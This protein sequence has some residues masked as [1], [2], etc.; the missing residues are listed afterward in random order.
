M[1]LSTLV[2]TITALILTSSL[3]NSPIQANGYWTRV[4]LR[5][6]GSDETL[7]AGTVLTAGG[8]VTPKSNQAYICDGTNNGAHTTPGGTVISAID[9]APLK[10]GWDGTWYK[11]FR[12]YLISS[13]ENEDG[14]SER[15][16]GLLVNYRLSN[17]GGCQTKVAADD[18]VLVARGALDAQAFLEARVNTA[19]FT[20]TTSGTHT[21]TFTVT[22]G[23]DRK[24]VAGATMIPGPSTSTTDQNGVVKLPVSNT[25]GTFTYKATGSGMIRSPPVI[26]TVVTARSSVFCMTPTP[27]PTSMVDGDGFRCCN[28]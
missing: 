27:T 18:Q 4:S 21:M 8:I 17:K 12:D 23:A 10:H 11:G 16:W 15:Y 6:E 22:N 9:D 19:T 24:L 7:Y 2:I 25:P 28:E 3:L 14:S 5:I 26:I 20:T 1:H 13:I